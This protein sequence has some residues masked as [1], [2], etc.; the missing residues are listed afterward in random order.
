MTTVLLA[1][2]D[3][4]ALG[5]LAEKTVP[6]LL[7]LRGAPILERALEALVAAGIR[8][9]LVVVGPRGSEIEK[10]FGKGIRWGIALEYV[11]REEDETT[12]AVLR[13]LEHRLD[14][15]SL[16]LR[17]DAAVE[18]AFG[19]FARRVGGRNEAVVTAVSGERLLGMW[20][21]RA[22]AL[23]KAE[24][25]RDPV[26]ADWRPA[27]DHARLDVGL[28]VAPLDGLPAWFALDRGD[29]KPI[30]SPRATVAGGAKLS[31]GATVAED[32]AVLAK[33]SLDGVSVLPRTVVPQGVSLSGAAVSQNLVVDP[34]TGVTS[35]LTDLLPAP[36]QARGGSLAGRLAGFALFLLSLPLWPVAFAW[37]FVANAGHATRPFSF[38]GNGSKA[39]S[40]ETVK[41]FR[42]ESAIP[43]FRDLPLL[44]AVLGGSLALSGVA[45]LAPEEETNPKEPWAVARLEAPVGLLARS[46]MVVPAAAPPEVARVVDAFDARNGCKGLV[47]LGLSTFLSARAWTAPRTWNPDQL[48]EERS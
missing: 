44:L 18:G 4:R 17:G 24:L 16:V 3:G 26:D 34:K 36:G 31:G 39:G 1:D 42:F 29:G 33:A 11:R 45:P 19:E 5:P 35:L 12:G 38:A 10:R 23:K 15:D 9:A 32:A 43:V 20:R 2:R 48:P 47:S 21:V 40:R 46:R 27:K 37:S 41:T 14:G 28:D 13:R 8:S 6:A 25:P 7:P 22:E 30:L